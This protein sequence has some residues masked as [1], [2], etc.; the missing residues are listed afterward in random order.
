MQA[1]EWMRLCDQFR[2]VMLPV[3]NFVPLMHFVSN[4]IGNAYSQ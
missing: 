2:D 1:A 3:G 4:G